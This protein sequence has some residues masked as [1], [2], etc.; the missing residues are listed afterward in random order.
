MV[1]ERGLL[2]RIVF[3]GRFAFYREVCFYREVSP[4]GFTGRFSREVSRKDL[5][6]RLRREAG[7]GS[8]P[9]PSPR[10][11]CEASRRCGPRAAVT[12]FLVVLAGVPELKE[13][14]C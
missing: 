11:F 7:G 2:G 10:I 1:S 3:T 8:R 13:T 5:A 14:L 6:G 9:L 12:R 4:G